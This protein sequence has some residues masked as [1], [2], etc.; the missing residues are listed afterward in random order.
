MRKRQGVTGNYFYGNEISKYGQENG[1]VDYRTLAKA[2]SHVDTGNLMNL[3]PDYCDNVEWQ[4]VNGQ[5]YHYEDS[6]GNEHT[7]DEAQEKITEL[8]EELEALEELD[9]LTKEQEERKDEIETDIEKLEE[10]RYKDFFN[11]LIIDNNGATILK[12]WTNEY[13]IYNE[14][15]NLYVWGIDHCGTSWD[16]VLTEIECNMGRKNDDEQTGTE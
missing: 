8:K 12:E 6:D 5:G 2:F 3:Y 15:L 16:Y 10:A 9:E 7:Y 1:R 11:Y 13:V 14:Q 4:V